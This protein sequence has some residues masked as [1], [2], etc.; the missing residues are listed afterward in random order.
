MNLPPWLLFLLL[1]ALTLALA[2]QLASRRYGWRV[3]AY[4]LFIFIGLAG[5]EA[6]SESAG[7]NMTRFGDL[8]LL[9]DLAGAG[10]TLSVLWFLGV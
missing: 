2:Y 5:F 8:R 7:F 1:L 9:P 6:L 3:L 10:A 4:W